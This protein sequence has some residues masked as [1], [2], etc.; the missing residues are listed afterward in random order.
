[1]DFIKAQLDRIQQQLAGLSATQRMLTASLVAI[2]LITVVWWG[3]YAGEAEMVPLVTQSLTAAQIG[4]MQGVLGDR[5]IT[6]QISGD[7]LMVHAD[8]RLEALSALTFARAMPRLTDDGFKE[9]LT[10]MNP[11]DSI[12]KSDKMWN[13]QKQAFLSQVIGG[14][15]GVAKADVM[16]DPT[17]SRRIEGNPDSRPQAEF[18]PPLAQ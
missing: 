3:K 16:I 4:Q 8:R 2:M 9:M 15:Q 7:R 5:G 12:E 10:Q 13:H 17:S 18:A 14:M 1:M 11:F 6:T